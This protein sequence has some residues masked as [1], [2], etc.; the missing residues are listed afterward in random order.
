MGRPS[1]YS[2]KVAN[3]VCKALS[4]GES[5]RAYCRKDDTPCMTTV[6]KW[7]RDVPDFAQQY[8]HARELQAEAMLDEIIEIADNCT[9]DVQ[10][11]VADDESGEGAKASIKH[12]AIQRARVQIDARKWVMGKMAPKKYSD[13]LLTEH[14]GLDGGP[15]K[16][17]SLVTMAPDEAY[18]RLLDAGS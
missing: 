12:S 4:D 14:S 16:T 13:K 17:E 9:D 7:L 2:E 8:A 18:R 1:T 10:F 3:A 15:I 6:M 5:L 11:L